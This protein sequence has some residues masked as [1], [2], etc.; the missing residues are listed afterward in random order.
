L[1]DRWDGREDVMNGMKE[2]RKGGREGG[3]QARKKERKKGRRAKRDRK[4]KCAKS[5][6][7]PWAFSDA[8][9]GVVDD[10]DKRCD[11]EGL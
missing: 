5:H 11:A 3:E 9:F 1:V 8:T 4:A 2:G 10:G 6:L 7:Q